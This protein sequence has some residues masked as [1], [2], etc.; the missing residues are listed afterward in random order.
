MGRGW[1]GYDP[2]RVMASGETAGDAV[3]RL[4][5]YGWNNDVRLSAMREIRR[6]ERLGYSRSEAEDE[7]YGVLYCREKYP[8]VGKDGVPVVGGAVVSSSGI[9]VS[10]KDILDGK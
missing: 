10:M 7:V 8:R 4:M 1:S 2:L 3:S 5:S 6:F 9:G